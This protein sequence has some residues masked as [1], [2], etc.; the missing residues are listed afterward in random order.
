LE[1][2]SQPERLPLGQLAYHFT[3]AAVY[4]GPEKAIDYA[5]RSGDHASDGLALEDAARYYGM[6]LRVLR[7]LPPG[8]A[9]DGER[10]NL[11]TKRGRSFFQVG[12]WAL[13]KGEFE[14]ALSFLNPAE[15]VKRCELL[16]NLAEAAFWLMDGRVLRS[17]AKAAELLADR[18]G[19]DDLW[20]DARAW[21]ASAEVADGDV[22]GGI[23]TDRQTLARVDGIRS[24]GLA[25]VPLTLYWAGRSSEAVGHGAQAVERARESGEPAFL[26]YALQHL[27]ISLSG[28]GRYD[29]ALRAFDEA[30]TLGRQCGSLPLLAR[31]MSMSVAP[32]LSLGDFDGATRRA[33]EVRELA[34]RVA[35]EPPLVSA[36]IDLLLIYARSQEPGRAEPLL[37]KVEYA[38]QQASGWHAWKWRMRLS[39]ARA[40]LAAASGNW[41]D[42]IMF[43]GNVIEQSE[44]RSRPKYQALGFATRARARGQLGMRQAVDDARVAVNIARRL[45]DP[46]VL[47]ECLGVL[48]EQDGNSDVFVE[49]QRTVE[50]ILG[51]LTNEPLRRTFMARLPVGIA[52][53]E[54][55]ASCW[56][57]R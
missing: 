7:L 8:P 43:A 5:V 2:L 20:A 22:L 28:A 4:H 14:L 23:E 29:E 40:E 34:H 56:A 42:A 3:E 25:R 12:W 16:V 39:Q 26:L 36:G 57:G 31:A 37:A 52:G 35:F 15:Q 44:T 50:S 1:R 21:M 18:I 38:V 9:V 32:L 41:M 45:S 11:H 6:A 33:M 51:T 19:R 17:S 27:G 13:A 30:C 54:S 10:L 49:W 53:A 24:F 48:L 47:L 46:A 55:A